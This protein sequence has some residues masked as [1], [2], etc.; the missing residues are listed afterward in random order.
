MRVVFLF[1]LVLVP[2]ARGAAGDSIA[3]ALPAKFDTAYRGDTRTAPV[4]NRDENFS[5][6]PVFY[7]LALKRGDDIRIDSRSPDTPVLLLCLYGPSVK[8]SPTLNFDDSDALECWSSEQD[9]ISL[10]G[11]PSGDYT[12][13][14]VGRDDGSDEP[15]TGRYVFTVKLLS[16]TRAAPDASAL[17]ARLI[18]AGT[19]AGV[20]WRTF[21]PEEKAA[22]LNYVNDHERRR[23]ATGATTE[24]AFQGGGGERCFEKTAG[25]AGW[26]AGGSSIDHRLW[27]VSLQVRWCER[28]G[29]V[30]RVVWQVPRCETSW[31]TWGCNG[32]DGVDRVVRDRPRDG[33]YYI[34]KVYFSLGNCIGVDL[35]IVSFQHCRRLQPWLELRLRP[36][37]APLVAHGGV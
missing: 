6:H 36:G 8:D 16:R 9:E 5:Y 27:Q 10:D 13:A 25:Y 30:S 29:R 28:G 14:V 34:V 26:L 33:R 22:V 35:K 21:S 3:S 37:R 15:W 32:R 11:R 31:P 23:P 20:V 7:R 24:L 4:Y 12:L 19:R 2:A 18:D 1:F 17:V